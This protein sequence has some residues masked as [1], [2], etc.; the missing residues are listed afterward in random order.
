MLIYNSGRLGRTTYVNGVKNENN[1][2][3]DRL[4]NTKIFLSNLGV[5]YWGENIEI[6]GYESHDNTRPVSL[7]G[8]VWL[9]NA[10]VNG[11][12]GNIL[13][14]NSETTRQGFRFYDFYVQTII[15]NTIFRNF[16]HS[17]AATKR[18]EDNVVITATTFSD[19]FKPQFISATKNITFQ[20]VPQSQIIGH[21]D[22]ANSGS[23][24]LFN[25]LDGDGSVTS[26][27]TG[28]PGIPQIVG[29]HVS[30]WKFD[31][32]CLFS[33]EWNVW[34][35]NKGTKGL[36]NIEFWVPGFMERELE[37]DPDSYIGSISL[38]GSGINDERKTLLTRNRKFNSFINQY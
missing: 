2:V 19:V 37:Q 9:H 27:F 35:C 24:R 17:T 28:K 23:S 32:S 10:L 5:G 14:K 36:A 20:N 8:N 31:D 7:F 30:W 15:S 38:F 26:S 33:T 1:V 25:F 21:E 12:S 18:D 11:Q 22:V 34:V 13:T 3:F 16:I 4:N 6:V 29:S